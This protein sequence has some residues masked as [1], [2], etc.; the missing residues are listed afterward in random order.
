MHH[1]H[2]HHCHI[3]TI[4]GAGCRL[5]HLAEV[6]PQGANVP[7]TPAESVQL[8]PPL[9]V[10]TRALGRVERQSPG[11][12]LYQRALDVELC[13]VEPDVEPDGVPLLAVPFV[14]RRPVR[15]DVKRVRVE[16]EQSASEGRS[17]WSCRII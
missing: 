9:P 15:R 3:V 8:Q 5:R 11:W 10:A 7:F 6:R 13:A 16:G 14:G 4:R 12:S 17:L 2:I 1:C